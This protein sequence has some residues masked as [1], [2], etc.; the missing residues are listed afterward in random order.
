MDKK[1]LVGSD[2]Q[3]KF[4]KLHLIEP[5][6]PYLASLFQHN[7]IIHL[8]FLEGDNVGRGDI[9]RAV[10]LSTPPSALEITIGKVVFNPLST[11]S[12]ESLV[13]AYE[14]TLVIPHHL[15]CSQFGC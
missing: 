15:C 3:I 9:Y 6:H 13:F 8:T 2:V 5:I 12:P 14:V 4:V 7:L 1:E 10:F 11:E